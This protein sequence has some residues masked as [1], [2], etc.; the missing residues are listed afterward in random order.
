MTEPAAQIGRR[1]VLSGDY[2]FSERST[3]ET[4]LCVRFC[5]TKASLEINFR[6]SFCN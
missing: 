3:D 1:C 4:M 5:S 2:V 6:H